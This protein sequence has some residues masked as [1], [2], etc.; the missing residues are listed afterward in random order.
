[1]TDMPENI[2]IEYANS[3]IQNYTQLF[4]F[5]FEILNSGELRSN[6]QGGRLKD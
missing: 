1:M 6:P 2:V 5:G 3:H 4:E